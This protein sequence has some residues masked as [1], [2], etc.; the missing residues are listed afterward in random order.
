MRKIGN[1]TSH[2]TMLLLVHT[3]IDHRKR[4][5]SVTSTTQQQPSRDIVSNN[6]SKIS[7]VIV[8]TEDQMLIQGLRLVGFSTQQVQ[9]VSLTQNLRRFKSHYGSH[10]IVY[11]QIWEDLQ[12]TPCVDALIDGKIIR[13]TM[14]LMTFNFLKC[15]PT[16]SQLAAS[17]HVCERSVRKWCRFY[18]Q[19]VQ[20]L[21]A[22]KVGIAYL[23]LLL[24]TI[25]FR[26][27]LIHK[28]V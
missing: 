20:A 2:L 3:K 12:T 17:F 28:I 7:M 13:L 8:V 11:S 27:T 10:P 16:E 9:K 15:Y 24:F 21:K 23:I 19:K 22:Q 26:P 25:I 1:G 6:L 18:A 4:G 5:R 14:F